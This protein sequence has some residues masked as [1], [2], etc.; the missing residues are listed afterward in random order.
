MISGNS[1]V[2][3]ESGKTATPSEPYCAIAA[4]AAPCPPP[5]ATTAVGLLSAPKTIGAYWKS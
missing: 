2:K 1:T 5:V 4:R 3:V